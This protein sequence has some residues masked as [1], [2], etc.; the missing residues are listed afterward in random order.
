MKTSLAFHDDDWFAQEG[1]SVVW[2]GIK[3][4]PPESLHELQARLGEYLATPDERDG[5]QAIRVAKAIGAVREAQA[6]HLAQTGDERMSS[7]AYERLQDERAK[8][9]WPPLTTVM[10]HLGVGSWNEVL[11]RCHLPEAP[12]GDEVERSNNHA[13]S[14]EEVIDALK[15]C[16]LELGRVPSLWEYLT[17]RVAADGSGLANCEAPFHTGG[18]MPAHCADVGVPALAEA[19]REARGLARPDHPR[20]VPGDLEVV[21]EMAVV[22]EAER[23]AAVADAAAA[24]REVELLA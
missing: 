22:L 19:D 3:A 4:L 1:A 24:Q 15:E 20:L 5:A 17:W 9:D 16:K 18:C 12:A 23:H 11:H 10:R 6:I 13:Y 21:L 8:Q 7:Y 2:A 14:V